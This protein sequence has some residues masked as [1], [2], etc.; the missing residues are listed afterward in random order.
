[1]AS[2]RTL[3]TVLLLFT[4]TLGCKDKTAPV[5]PAVA[6]SEE[7]P[8]PSQTSN[9]EVVEG[10]QPTASTPIAKI[11]DLVV[12][13]GDFDEASRLS[14]LFSPTK[15]TSL[16]PEQLAAPHVHTTMTQSLIAQK[17]V[18]R[19]AEKRG[20]KPT[21]E[22]MH[23][24]LREHPRLAVYGENLDD[25]DALAAQLEP[26]GL[27]S[28]DLLKVAWIELESTMLASSMVAAITDDEVWK[29]YEFAQTTRTAA[30]VTASNVPT[31]TEL[32]DWVERNGAQID[33]HFQKHQD[34]Y[35]TPKRVKLNI[36]RP[37]A[38]ASVENTVLERASKMLG[39]GIQPATVAA[40]LGLQA[41]LDLQLVRGENPAAFAMQPAE[42]GW[43][44]SGPR[45]AYAWKVVGFESSQPA[46]LSRPLRREIAAELLR[47]SGVVPSLAQ[48]LGEAAKVLEKEK[49]SQADVERL[50][51]TPDG[52]DQLR[53]KIADIHPGFDLV[54]ATF[55]NSSTHPLPKLGLAEE[56]IVGA[57][58]VKVGETTK[59]L[60]SR[61]RG[62]IAHVFAAN[63][64]TR[65]AFDADVD[66]H[67]REF[68]AALR[69]RIVNQW[70]Q[71]QMRERDGSFDVT[72]LR[73]K[74]GVLKKEP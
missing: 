26:L 47:T 59:P 43:T 60:L 6:A 16:T 22:Q 46:E 4:I 19:E 29:T 28:K 66:K 64:P 42:V 14:L 44:A 15:Q 8:A 33:A 10:P 11:D 5:E 45:G 52:A 3:F 23:A 49:L 24:H 61:E 55:P 38:G 18:S 21:I 20:L 25:P 12:T 54:V 2:R 32:D 30:V 39:D 62:A 65:A 36:V 56:V 69:P 63:I 58:A 13:V 9:I 27:T 7:A 40:E 17:L 67:R 57:F 50:T 51:T 71:Q 72:P 68:L 41:D 1:M 37:A 31:S 53:A 35:R 74:Y 34:R 73:I 48:K 70:V